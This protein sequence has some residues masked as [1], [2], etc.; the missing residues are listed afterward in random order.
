MVDIRTKEE[1]SVRMS[2]IHSTSTKPEMKL[3]HVLGNQ[4]FRYRVNDKRFPGTPDIV[5]PKYRNVVF[6]HG[7]FWHGHKGC[8]TCHIPGINTAFWTAKITRNQ[9]RDQKVWRQLEAKGWYVIIVRKCQ[10]KSN[11][12]RDN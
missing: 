6:V 10:L 4:R 5:L 8:P 9:Q 2:R 12:P 3:R 7:C 11:S 1:R